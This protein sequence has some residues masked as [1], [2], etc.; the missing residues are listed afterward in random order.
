MFRKQPE[1]CIHSALPLM[2]SYT[3]C[4]CVQTDNVAQPRRNT[5]AL[6]L[7]LTRRQKFSD[8]LAF[9]YRTKASHV[10]AYFK[11]HVTTRIR[12]WLPLGLKHT[13]HATTSHPHQTTNSNVIDEINL[14][15]SLTRPSAAPVS[16]SC[17]L[18]LYASEFTAIGPGDRLNCCCLKQEKVY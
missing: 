2:E 6:T 15:K 1:Q 16:R 10:H 17:P 18:W 7:G 12:T 9:E 11:N 4:D 3:L 14:P 13:E 5:T 8:S